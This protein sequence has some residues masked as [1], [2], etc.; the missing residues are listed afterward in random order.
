MTGETARG[1]QPPAVAFE[2]PD[3]QM[4]L[5][6]GGSKL[7]GRLEEA[8]GFGDIRREDPAPVAVVAQHAP[9]PAQEVPGM[10]PIRS[11]RGDSYAMTKSTWSRRLRPT[12]GK[13]HDR[14]DAHRAQ[15]FCVAHP[16]QQQQLR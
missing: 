3:A 16:R 8:A 1:V 9:E 15:H 4:Q 5:N 14:A 12:P 2:N 6:V 10:K 7:G 11:F 13:V